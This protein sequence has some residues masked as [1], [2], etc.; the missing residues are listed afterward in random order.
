MEAELFQSIERL[1]GSLLPRDLVRAP[2][3]I[4]ELFLSVCLVEKAKFFRPDSIEHYPSGRGL[5]LFV[6]RVTVDFV[7]A[8]IRIQEAHFFMDLDLAFRQADL[9]LCRV[10]E[11]A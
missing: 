4:A 9:D 5:D 1:H 11:T 10:M 8:K 3:D 2:D 7:P 6:Q